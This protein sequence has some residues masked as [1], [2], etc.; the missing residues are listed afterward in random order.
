MSTQNRKT[1]IIL[2]W[3]GCKTA[4]S[5]PRAGTGGWERTI[6]VAGKKQIQ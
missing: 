2:H 5:N 3:R 1:N 4:V 6:M